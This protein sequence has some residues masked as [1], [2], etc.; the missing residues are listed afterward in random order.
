MSREHDIPYDAALVNGVDLIHRELKSIGY[1][2]TLSFDLQQG[3]VEAQG[4][5][6]CLFTLL[7]QRQVNSKRQV[8]HLERLEC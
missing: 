7:Q 2:R 1:H 8:D 4:V 5:I 3:T 6:K